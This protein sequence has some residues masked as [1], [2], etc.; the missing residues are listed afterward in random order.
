MAIDIATVILTAGCTGIGVSI[1]N[2]LFDIY[3]KDHLKKLKKQNE[4]LKNLRKKL[5]VYKNPWIA[6][7]L[8]LVLWGTGYFFVKRKR[9]LGTLLLLVQIFIIG[10][11][12]FNQDSWKNIFEGI[13]YIFLTII[14][15]IYLGVDAY[16]QAKEVN[17]GK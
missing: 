3:F 5:S 9:L 2:G 4:R 11:F 6:A 14:I 15:S 7:I 12:A 16:R 13:S 1:G 8:N 10:G 17:V